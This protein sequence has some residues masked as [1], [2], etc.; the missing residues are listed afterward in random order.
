LGTV[1][2]GGFFDHWKNEQISRALIKL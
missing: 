2:L 1:Q